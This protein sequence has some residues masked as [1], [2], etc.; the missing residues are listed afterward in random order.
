MTPRRPASCGRTSRRTSRPCPPGWYPTFRGITRTGVTVN[1]TGAA[2]AF[3]PGEKRDPVGRWTRGAGASPAGFT[4][5]PAHGKP[6]GQL[7]TWWRRPATRTP[8]P[9]R[10]LNDGHALAAAI[11]KTLTSDPGP[12]AHGDAFPAWPRAVP[13]R[14]GTPRSAPA[15]ATTCRRAPI[16]RETRHRA[17]TAPGSLVSVLSIAAAGCPRRARR[18]APTRGRCA[19]GRSPPPCSRCPAGFPWP[20]S[21]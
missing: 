10:V 18:S 9:R 2:R 11:D 8:S 7:A 4:E 16:R 3:R 14:P 5:N 1:G 21:P 6:A 13:P 15:P 19:C 20:G 17:R 12:F